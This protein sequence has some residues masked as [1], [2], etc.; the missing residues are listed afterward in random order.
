MVEQPVTSPE[1][2]TGKPAAPAK[3]KKEKESARETIESVIFAF[4]L[5]FLF[6]TF[7]AE[8]FVIP[9]G[10]MAPTLFGRHKEIHCTEC[11]YTFEIGASREVLRDG[12]IINPGAGR[13]RMAMC[14]NCRFDNDSAYDAPPYKGDR[15]LVNKFQYE[16]KDPRRFDVV[17]FK[18]PEDAKTNYIK[19]LVGLPGETLRIHH[20]NVYKVTGDGSEEILRKDDLEKMRAIQIPVYDD[21]Y[22]PKKLNEAGWPDRWAAMKKAEDP[23][24]ATIASWQNQNDSWKLDD[25][26]RS[27]TLAA[28]KA[29][30]TSWLRYRHIVPSRQDWM[31]LDNGEPFE[32]K[33]R[34]VGDF[35]G[36]NEVDLM[37]D[38]GQSVESYW[39]SDLSVS[40]KA[41]ISNAQEGA[42]FVIELTEGLH[43]YR[44]RI[45]LTT[46]QLTLARVEVA[47]DENEEIPVATASTSV[48]GN[49][50][51][52]FEF[53]NVDDQLSVW[54][55]DDRVEFDN[56]TTYSNT[57]L[58]GML[59][60]DSD[61]TPVGIGLQ[62]A[63]GKISRLEI[64]RDIYYRGGSVAVSRDW[65]Q[66]L[67]DVG[68]WQRAYRNRGR[69]EDYFEVTI[70][71]NEYFVLG[72]NSPESSD[73]RFWNATNTVPRDAFVGKAFFI[74]WPHGIPLGQKG[75]VG[76]PVSFHKMYK[77]NGEL[78]T[79]RSYPIHYVPFYPNFWR[80]QR[81]R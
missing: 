13:I 21:A 57:Q 70:P 18:F 46:G 66:M 42:Q 41:E 35:C 45:D 37:F 34:I 6:R 76:I 40:G 7:E 19:R 12:K 20:G 2:P 59:P 8:A 30:Q 49:D 31:K 77:R 17:V 62:K 56:P 75:T 1:T 73:G 5:A 33:P 50:T 27:Y 44:C 9:T 55:D 32:P 71:Q 81:I 24:A 36:Y 39:V 61:Y 4:I 68:Q 79:D 53:A 78:V 54:I 65:N 69:D 11:G 72:D 22:P 14:P 67:G 29:D 23:Q 80:M 48:R 63:G 16:L 25:A 47:L 10:S 74:Y 52:T 60:M 3:P 26:S 51:F 28:D 58:H 38:D 15:I 43:W 64:K